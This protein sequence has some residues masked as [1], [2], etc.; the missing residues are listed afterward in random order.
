MATARKKYKRFMRLGVV[1]RQIL[2]DLSAGDLLIGFL[3]SAHSTK[4][5][6]RV[7]RERSKQRY[8][9]RLA[10][11]RLAHGGYIRRHGETLSISKTGQRLLD[12]TVTSVRASLKTKQWDGKWRIVT[13]DIPLN[14]GPLRFQVHSILKRA[15]FAKLQHSV[16]IF[17]HECEELTALIKEDTRLRG[18]VLYGVLDRIEDDERFRTMFGFGQ[19]K[20]K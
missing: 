16:W 3:C 12:R 9:M 11:E 20:V 19:G 15:G 5:M 1:E 18:R 6:F 7:A 10:I 2:E 14:F 8:N 17:P 4:T 13:Y